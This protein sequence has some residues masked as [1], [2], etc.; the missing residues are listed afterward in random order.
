MHRAPANTQWDCSDLGPTVL[1]SLISPCARG[2]GGWAHQ[3]RLPFPVPSAHAG[4]KHIEGTPWIRQ[5][6]QTPPLLNPSVAFLRNAV[7]PQP[8]TAWPQELGL[9]THIQYSLCNARCALWIARGGLGPPL[10]IQRAGLVLHLDELGAEG[11][12]G[13]PEAVAAHLNH[14]G[15]GT[16]TCSHS[17]L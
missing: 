11:H 5:R 15:G 10:V 3:R 7:Q 16:R 12:V 1:P 2:S 17:Q 9:S 8:V 6:Q 4:G 13:H 14:P